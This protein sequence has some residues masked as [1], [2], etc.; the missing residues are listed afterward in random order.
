MAINKNF[1]I[2]D[3]YC[4][5]Y[6][7]INGYDYDYYITREG[8]V[9]TTL[10]RGGIERFLK[11]IVRN[12]YAYVD[13]KKNGVPKRCAIHRLVAK[14]FIPNP[15]KKPYVNHIDGNRLNNN[16]DNLEWC[17]QKE[18]M[19]HA[20]HVLGKCKATEKSK[21]IASLQGKKNR[22]LTMEQAIE[23]RRLRHE[24]KTTIKE[25]S[26]LFGLSVGCVKGIL[27]EKTY[28]E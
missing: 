18:N 15:Y 2:I 17:T 11:P 5:N 19:H 24:N 13:F 22:K 7:K 14:E 28:K 25:L 3:N 27:Y 1:D 6:K 16:V 4:S 10:R 12:G 21:A 9:W 8:M 26:S 23:M 20:H